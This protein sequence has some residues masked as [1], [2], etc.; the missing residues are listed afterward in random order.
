MEQYDFSDPKIRAMVNRHE[1][2]EVWERPGDRF[3]N[4][5]AVLAGIIC[6]ECRAPWPCLPVKQLEIWELDQILPA[7]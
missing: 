5:Q 6:N 4:K 1:P 2:A 3:L 7:E